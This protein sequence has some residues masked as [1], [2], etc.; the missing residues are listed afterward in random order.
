MQKRRKA[1]VSTLTLFI[2]VCIVFSPWP[3]WPHYAQTGER[4]PL[5]RFHRASQFTGSAG[6]AE[7]GFVLV[8]DGEETSCRGMTAREEQELLIEGRRAE[9][10]R[11]NNAQ[12]AGAAQGLKI[13]LR[14]TQQLEGF[15]QAKDAVLRAAAKWEAT[16]QT[17]ITIVID[18]DFG[19]TI[20]GTPYPSPNIIG[21]TMAQVQV[22]LNGYGLVREALLSR[23]TSAEQ[24]NTYNSLPGMMPTDLGSTTA[25]TVATPVLRAL[26]RLP[27]TAEPGAEPALGAP[28]A[29]GF[30]SRS[31]ERRVGK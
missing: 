13:I 28:P 26:G 16:I 11:L 7:N 17:P 8:R 29:I 24:A 6:S 19:A 2:A 30:H 12:R 27:A 25:V 1:T 3:L 22:D 31:E 18:V 14:G 5:D 10:H 15:P 21:A 20:F 9:S 23:A 4:P